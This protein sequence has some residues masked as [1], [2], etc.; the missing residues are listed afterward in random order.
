MTNKGLKHVVAEARDSF[1][2]T[3]EGAD[4]SAV[5]VVD[6]VSDI[7]VHTLRGANAVGSEL[8]TVG[9]AAVTGVV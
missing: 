8:I 6:A 3:V 7:M 5:A 9:A 1:I 4:E 2:G